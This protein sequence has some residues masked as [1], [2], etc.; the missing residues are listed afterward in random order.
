MITTISLAPFEILIAANVGIMRHT[1]NL[2]RRKSNAHGSTSG[3]DWQYH[4][5]GALGEYAVARALGLFW[6]GSIGDL[7]ASDVGKYQV[8]TRSRDYYDLIIHPSDDDGDRFILVTGQN[9]EYELRGWILGQ[10]GKMRGFWKDPASNGRHA[11]FV[12][13]TMLNDMES[14]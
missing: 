9:G 10:E 3:N 7:A 1:Q 12:P 2:K 13:Q 14:L 11:Y 6:N 4:V 8:R 5:E